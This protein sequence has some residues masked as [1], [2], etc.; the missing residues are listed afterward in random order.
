ML[1]SYKISDYCNTYHPKWS[2]AMPQD[3]PPEDIQVP[4]A[5]QF[6]RLA[7]Q[8]NDADE[9]DFKSY[10]ELYPKRQWGEMLPFAMGLSVID[11]EARARKNLKLPMFRQYK[12]II[13]MVLNPE[14]GVVKQTGIHQS[15]Y[16]WWRT[17]SF[18][19]SNIKMLA[20]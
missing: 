18:Q 20:I 3:C 14:D 13:C 10:A 1:K 6:F 17:Q 15:H 2:C 5:H 12:G 7:R 16:T 9:Q 11:N 8:S 4:F 19:L